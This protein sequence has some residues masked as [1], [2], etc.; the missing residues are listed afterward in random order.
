MSQTGLATALQRLSSGLRINSAKDDAA[1]LSISNRMTSQIRGMDQ[2][3]RNAN[4]GISLAQTAE[5]ALG[6]TTN[7]L[8]R[9]RELSIQSSNATNSA[10]D[11]KSLQAEVNQLKSE[12]SRIAN[13]TN[14]NGNKLL[15]GSFTSQNFQVGADSNQTIGISVAGATAEILG[16]NT[17]TT[18]NTFDGITAATG[19]GNP[20]ATTDGSL[21][22]TALSGTTITDTILQTAIGDQTIT[23]T[24]GDGST[25]VTMDINTSAERSAAAIAAAFTGQNGVTSATATNS[26]TVETAGLAATILT[27]D[28]VSFTLFGDGLPAG[29][30]LVSF[31]RGSGASLA[32]EMQTALN[33][34]LSGDITSVNNA[35][36][37]TLTSATGQNIGVN[38]FSVGEAASVSLGVASN[39]SANQTVS[40]TMTA[41]GGAATDVYTISLKDAGGVA[42]TI[43]TAAVG[44]AGTAAQA[45]TA[46]RAALNTEFGTPTGG[47]D[48]TGFSVGAVG[49]AAFNLTRA[50]SATG[51]ATEISIGS[52]NETINAT[53]TQTLTVA[54]V[55]NAGAITGTASLARAAGTNAAVAVSTSSTFQVDDVAVTFTHDGTAGNF[56]D[57]AKAQLDTLAVANNWIV[58]QGG[59]A[60]TA[61]TLKSN[62]GTTIKIDDFTETTGGTAATIAVTVGAGNTNSGDGTLTAGVSPDAQTFT[63]TP[64][65]QTLGFNGAVT[66]TEGGT[67]SAVKVGTVAFALTDGSTIASSITTS[68][69]AG[70]VFSAAATVNAGA[71]GGLT[72]VSGG[73]N[74]AAQ[75]LTLVGGSSS[76]VDIALNSSAK[77]IAGAINAASGTTGITAKASTSAT[78]SSLSANGTVSFNLYGSNTVGTSVS[79]TVTTNDLTALVTAI[80]NKTGNTGIT[81]ELTNSGTSI[82]LSQADGYDIKIEDFGHSAA[83]VSVLESMRVTG[84]SGDAITLKDG[85]GTTTDST[86]VGGQ[87]TFTASD[88]S[89]SVQSDLAST[90]GGL[91]TGAASSAQASTLSSLSAIDISTAAGAQSAVDVID[92]ALTTVNGIRASL[93]A[94]QN[95]FTSTIASLQTTSENISGARSRIQD[96]DFAA[97]TAAL[98]RG[99]ILQQAGTA[100]LAQANSLPNSVLFP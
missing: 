12:L 78:L 39:T 46:L 25:A 20:S 52:L 23:V 36:V 85:L 42:R 94:V 53:G 48:W 60:G 56:M 26:V 96:A 33:G 18:N 19:T 29:G 64:V 2:A 58:T 16:V 62:N 68:G 67:D 98:T 77:I 27:G 71:V 44:G 66:L 50:N 41:A 65:T 43:T 35:G 92:G 81:A 28:K 15:D 7:L 84:G 37:L 54:A 34:S 97:E 47:A 99:Q 82:S 73:N 11:R 57:Q 80:N 38:N 5:G 70:S 14:F 87:V 93:G 69:A 61:I 24:P 21:M 95:R 55:T 31:V 3:V 8:Q 90:A 89:F 10:S 49:G 30:S 79:A 91:F 17:L 74:V 83:S 51:A 4:D 88:S 22:G 76:T 40:L 45:A 9:M 13:T 75:Q 32:A 6:E 1:G 63:K 100:M 72:D 86:V 59:G